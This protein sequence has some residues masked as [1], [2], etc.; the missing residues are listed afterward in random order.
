MSASEPEGKP[1]VQRPVGTLRDYLE[2]LWRRRLIV[3]QAI[4]LA[5]LIAVVLSSRQAPSYQAQARVLL[6]AEPFAQQLLTNPQNL[7]ANQQIAEGVAANQARLAR[8]RAILRDTLKASR[9]ADLTAAQLLN[10]SS[11]TAGQGSDQLTFSVTARKPALA[12]SLANAYALSYTRYRHNLDTSALRIA[13]TDLARRIRQLRRDPGG[14]AALIARLVETEQ[15]LQTLEALQTSNATVVE[16]ANR[17]F[18]VAPRPK[19]NAAL[20]LALGV[21]VGFLLALL[22]EA[23]DTRVRSDEEVAERLGVPLLGRLPKP[24]RKLRE[25]HTLVML[26]E[27]YGSHAE[28]IRMLRT[29]LELANIDQ[30]CRVIAIASALP[31]EGKSTTVANLAIALARDGRRVALVDLDLRKP[32]LATLFKAGARWGVTDV[33]LGR[34]PLDEALLRVD[35]ADDV[36]GSADSTGA[37]RAALD[38]LVSGGVPPDPGEFVSSRRLADM[39]TELRSRYDLVFVDTPPILS[40]GDALALSSRLDAFVVVCSLSL[41]RRGAL[42]ELRG[43][44]GMVRCVILGAVITSWDAAGQYGYGGGYYGYRGPTVEPQTAP[45]RPS[46]RRRRKPKAADPR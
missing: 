34:A 12:T 1:E 24:P 3:L 6:T 7:D 5:P 10:S 8:V 11:V 14:S 41:A 2:M 44:F 31:L 23:L 25:Q 37:A 16:T 18:K 33:A 42:Q 35:V 9:G 21:V 38:V 26:D 28:A 45:A 4:I 40:V 20:G 27:P 43:A 13:G 32:M 36:H 39:L 22:A 29:N 46:T 19:R 15:Q 17:A 30:E